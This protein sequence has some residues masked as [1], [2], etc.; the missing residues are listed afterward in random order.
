MADGRTVSEE[1]TDKKNIEINVSEETE[2]AETVLDPTNDKIEIQF[3]TESSE[4]L[5]IL[6]LS[7]RKAIYNVDKNETPGDFEDFEDFK[8]YTTNT[9]AGIRESIDSLNKTNV[10]NGSVNVG[11]EMISDFEEFK[12]YTTKSM[13]EIRRGS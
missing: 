5:P 13:S 2:T 11:Q 10:K 4:L 6:P 9:L 3:V 12:M 1:T 7:S 8:A